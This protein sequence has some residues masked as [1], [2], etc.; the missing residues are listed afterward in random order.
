MRVIKEAGGDKVYT[1]DN[2]NVTLVSLLGLIWP[3]TLQGVCSEYTRFL[4]YVTGGL[5]ELFSET[6]GTLGSKV[7]RNPKSHNRI[8]DSKGIQNYQSHKNILWLRDLACN[9]ITVNI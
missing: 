2:L 3:L 7:T 5:Y 6:G 4:G 9:N 8:P 1:P